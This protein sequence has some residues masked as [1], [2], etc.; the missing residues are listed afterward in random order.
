MSTNELMVKMRHMKAL[1]SDYLREKME[2]LHRSE[3]TRTMPATDELDK[4]DQ[5]Y[6][7]L[8]EQE[9]RNQ[10]LGMRNSVQSV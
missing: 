9:E 6:S 4:L 8:V 3:A 10:R 2:I 5:R 1:Q 7:A